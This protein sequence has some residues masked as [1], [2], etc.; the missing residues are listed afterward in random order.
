MAVNIG[1]YLNLGDPAGG[2]VLKKISGV[3]EY[4]ALF[5]WLSVILKNIYVLTAVVLFLMIFVAGIGMIVSAGDVEKQK[6]SSKTLSSA[7]IGFVILFLSYWLI[8]II[9]Y[10]TGIQIFTFV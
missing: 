7:V 2:G 10:L 8:K 1:D 4:Q 9:E 6:A 3:T 5:P